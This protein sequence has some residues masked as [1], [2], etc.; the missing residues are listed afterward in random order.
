MENGDAS[1]PVISQAVMITSRDATVVAAAVGAIWPICMLNALPS[2]KP[3]HFKRAARKGDILV[4]FA[5]VENH[6]HP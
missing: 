2:W 4:G 5:V 1:A 6:C 3:N